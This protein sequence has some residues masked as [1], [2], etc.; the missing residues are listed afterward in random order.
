[1]VYVKERFT[2][3]KSEFDSIK[4]SVES[5]GTEVSKNSENIDTAIGEITLIKGEVSDQRDSI[6]NLNTRVETSESTLNTLQIEISETETMVS[7]LETKVASTEETINTLSSEFTTTKED[8][9]TIKSDLDGK[10]STLTGHTPGSLLVATEEGSVECCGVKPEDFLLSSQASEV[11][12]TKE[13]LEN[14]EL[15]GGSIPVETIESLRSEIRANTES[16]SK[17]RE[18]LESLEIPESGSDE[19]LESLRSEVATLSESV[20][21]LQENFDNLDYPTESLESLRSEIQSNSESIIRLQETIDSL[22]YSEDIETLKSQSSTLISDVSSIKDDLLNKVS[23]LEGNVSGALVVSNDD[24]SIECCGIKPEDLLLA[25]RADEVYATKE[26]L[27]N[28]VIPGGSTPSTGSDISRY[29]GVLPSGELTH[30][31]PLNG[32]TTY[33]VSTHDS[34]TGE[35]L[36]VD[37]EI[38][39]D[40]LV[41]SIAEPYEHD[42]TIFVIF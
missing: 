6:N 39:D 16:I 23:L 12:A 14:L 15:S 25:S 2:E 7:N 22:E 1:M 17:L 20:S 29:D 34:V 40:T 21:K 4:T 30:S 13:D 5:L 18:D 42:I 31:I 37:S 24:G 41:L 28:L 10:V 33:S 9:T 27:K 38:S 19:S 35:V 3:V 32:L 36:L 8:I 26:D 11:Y